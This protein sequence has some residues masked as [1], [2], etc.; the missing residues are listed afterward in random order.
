MNGFFP[1]ATIKTEQSTSTSTKSVLRSKPTNHTAHRRKISS[2]RSA[3]AL[4]KDA[5][6]MIAAAAAAA[7]RR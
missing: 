3:A 5:D 7:A 1:P 6:D 2:L 4:F